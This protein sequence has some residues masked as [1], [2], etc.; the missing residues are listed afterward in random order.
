MKKLFSFMVSVSFLTSLWA[1]KEESVAVKSSEKKPE[2]QKPK[3]EMA[4]KQAAKENQFHVEVHEHKTS[5]P[6]DIWYIPSNKQ[7]VSMVVTFKGCGLKNTNLIHPSLGSFLGILGK[8]CGSLNDREFA[9]KLHDGGIS[10][11]LQAGL[12]NSVLSFWA[13]VIS[14]KD[15]F[16]LAALMCLEPKLPKKAF[17]KMQINA[18]NDFKESL[19]D[20]KTHLGE[21]VNATFY[22][23]KHP[24]RVSLQAEENDIQKIKPSDIKKFLNLLSQENA[25]VVV[26]GPRDKEDEICQAIERMLLKFPKKS[27]EPLV[28]VGTMLTPQ[29]DVQVP[30]EIPQTMIVGRQ[31]GVEITDPDFYAKR[32]AIAIVARSSLDAILFRK[33]REDHGLAYYCYGDNTNCEGGA[34]FTVRC[35]TRNETADQARQIIRKVLDDL[36]HKG[37]SQEDFEMGKKFFQGALIVGLDS[38]DRFVSYFA[39]GRVLGLDL[40]RIQKTTEFYQQVSREQVNQA[41]KTLFSKPLVF[42]SIGKNFA[43]KEA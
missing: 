24:Y 28:K 38:S 15:G 33:V 10:I 11:N 12:D 8:G 1:Q 42:V 18:L 31:T 25:Q 34:F 20:S 36:V 22:D 4:R 7:F 30:F 14:Y 2:M 29:K 27:S 3:K 19:K 5:L 40:Q 23:S 21:A 6:Y 16:D 41:C 39:S 32:L 13:P 26:L 17:K 35:G 9:Q 43:R 37:V